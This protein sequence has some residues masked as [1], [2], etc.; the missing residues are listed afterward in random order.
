MGTRALNRWIVATLIALS[1][2][3]AAVAPLVADVRTA[4]AGEQWDPDGE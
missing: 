4:L 2:A 3:T 1:L